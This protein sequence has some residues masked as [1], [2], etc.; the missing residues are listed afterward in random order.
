MGV[1]WDATNEAFLFGVLTS[2]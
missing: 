2:Y 1:P